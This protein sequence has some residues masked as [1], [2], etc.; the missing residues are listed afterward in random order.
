MDSLLALSP[1]EYFT[2]VGPVSPDGRVLAF[3]L[4]LVVDRHS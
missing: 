4:T 1:I 3:C 2:L